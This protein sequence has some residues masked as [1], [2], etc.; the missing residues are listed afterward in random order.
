MRKTTLN[1]TAGALVTLLI[2]SMLLPVLAFGAVYFPKATVGEDG[3]VVQQVYFTPDEEVDINELLKIIVR[4]LNGQEIDVA[5][6][7]YKHADKNGNLWF[8][9]TYNLSVGDSVYFDYNGNISDVVYRQAP[10]SGGPGFIGWF[11]SGATVID[12]VID[13]GQGTEVSEADLLKAFEQSLN[14]VV[15]TKADY[16]KLPASALAEAAK[17]AGATITIVNDNGS[18]E[19]PLTVFNYNALA[20][21]LDAD[22]KDVKIK[23]QIK[24]ADA[25][26]ADAVSKAINAIGAKQIAKAVDFSITAEA[27][28]NSIEVNDFGQTFVK[29]TLPVEGAVNANSVTAVTYD[30][31][32]NQL[33]FVP[34][35]FATKDGET[36]ATFKRNSNS[37]YT[38]ISNNQTFDDVQGHW[39][40]SYI[41]LLANKLV[42]NGVGNGKFSPERDINRAEF[43]ALLVRSLGLK[44]SDEASSFSD[45][46]SN[47]WYAGVVATAAEAGLVN[48]Y[49]DGTFRPDNTITR[50]E[51]AAMVVRAVA[52]AGGDIQVSAAESNQLL[53]QYSDASNV[54]WAKTEMA[55]A[56][57][58]GIVQG[59]SETNL[60]PV[61]N[62]TRAQSATM[63]ERY[64]KYVGFIN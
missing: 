13:L 11:G 59:T 30:F 49:T 43:A 26:I 34:S 3:T 60:R 23:V 2:A 6:A 14:V 9:F 54:T 4:D 18:Y 25:D 46:S 50:Q 63:L 7:V 21:E 47:A 16:V 45:V 29:R 51:I 28:I 27:Y 56:I 36:T 35:T 19:L 61:S 1:K 12:G 8:D 57:K 5:Y 20:K 62:A 41:E 17:K 64:L 58:S 31:D 32:S 22:L 33:Q 38:V 44:I 10:P 37:V 55:A 53:A 24:E 15:K 40:Q 52:Y 48:G 42:V 39:G